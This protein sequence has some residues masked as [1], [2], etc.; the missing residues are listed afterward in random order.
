[1]FSFTCYL[2]VISLAMYTEKC[3][4]D[5]GTVGSGLSGHPVVGDVVDSLLTQCEKI[6]SQDVCTGP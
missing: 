5:V 6:T 4:V 3:K 1:M 2:N